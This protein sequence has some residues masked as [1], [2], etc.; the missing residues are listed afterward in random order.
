MHVFSRDSMTVEYYDNEDDQAEFP[1]PQEQEPKVSWFWGIRRTEKLLLHAHGEV[2]V[3]RSKLPN[4]EYKEPLILPAHFELIAF[5][6]SVS[7]YRTTE[8]WCW[9]P[10]TTKIP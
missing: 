2:L 7:V 10:P 1:T 9:P 3:N 6:S 8:V 4:V 5:I